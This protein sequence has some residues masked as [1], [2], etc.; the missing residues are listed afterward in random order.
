[1]TGS[2]SESSSPDQEFSIKKL[3]AAGGGKS[4]QMKPPEAEC[5]A[6]F[7]IGGISP[8]GQRNLVRTVVEQSA[9]GQEQVYING[10]QRGLRLRLNQPMRD[11]LKA[12]VA[13]VVA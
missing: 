5:V 3:A 8:F 11:V 10:G 12:V 13:G 7:E 6:G 4:A 2:R 9:L 1:M